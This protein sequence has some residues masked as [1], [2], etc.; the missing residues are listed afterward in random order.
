MPTS[1]ESGSGP[2]MPVHHKP[3][4]LDTLTIIAMAVLAYILADVLHEGVGHGGACLLAG[5]KPQMLSSVH[6]ESDTTSLSVAARKFIAA[7]G[8][9]LNLLAGALFWGLLRGWQRAGSS[10]K[11]F[12]W[13]AM[14]VNLFT[15]AG[16]FLFSGVGNIGDWAVVIGGWQPHYLWRVGMTAGGLL[17]YLAMVRVALGEMGRLIGGGA[18][19]QFR[20]AKKLALVPYF[21]G[22]ITSVLA[23][24]FNPVG[25]ILVAISA[26]AST[27][28]GT[29]AFA[30]M[31]EVFPSG[32]F[33]KS[34]G[35]PLEIPRSLGWIFVGVLVFIPF[36]L[37][38]GPGIPLS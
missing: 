4:A 35:P 5:G 7:G 21:A 9:L 11:Y 22:G 17:L 32:R 15:G 12:L 14:S 13:L 29:S 19:E 36:V 23:G 30:W 25:M 28:G 6:F 24:L 10:M 38:L 37:W 33:H 34:P 31:M 20:R 27:F 8:T 26:G 16:Y 3:V 1:A 18:P 2:S